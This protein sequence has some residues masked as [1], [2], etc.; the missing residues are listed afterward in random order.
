MQTFSSRTSLS[1]R[2]A[3]IS[4]RLWLSLV[5]C[6]F[7]LAPELGRHEIFYSSLRV[8]RFV[9]KEFAA[10]PRISL[11]LRELP[12]HPSTAHHSYALPTFREG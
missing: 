7:A 8:V 9:V 10:L 5:G 4:V 3:E 1:V 6:F 2:A 11:T 12:G